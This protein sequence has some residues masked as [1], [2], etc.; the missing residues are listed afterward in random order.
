M[1]KI[2]DT[3]EKPEADTSEKTT[4]IILKKVLEKFKDPE[5]YSEIVKLKR[6]DLTTLLLHVFGDRASELRPTDL[7]AQFESDRFVQP[8]GVSQKEFNEFDHTSF[9]S[10][11]TDIEVIELS[12][13]APIGSNSVLTRISQNN[14]LTTSRSTE[15]MADTVT[16]LAMECAKRRKKSSS[17]IHLC[18]SHRE[19][20]AQ[21]FEDS[22]GFLPHFRG[23]SLVS[24]EKIGRD[25]KELSEVIKK[26]IRFYLKIISAAETAG[27]VD[28]KQ[29]IVKISS[30]RILNALINA[31]SLDRE[32]LMRNTGNREYSLFAENSITLP[33]ELNPGQVIDGELT[34][35]YR[36][37]YIINYLTRICDPI[38]ESLK[39]E[40]PSVQFQYDLSRF[41]GLGYYED[42]CFKI[43]AINV[44]GELIPLAD[45]G[46]TD[47]TEK[48]L[49]SKEERCF[50]GGF[51][52][53]FFIS[54]FK[55][56]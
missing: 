24:S 21:K 43:K 55:K 36:V 40:F 8:S 45:A 13:V 6:E 7:Q 42:L 10:L 23:I 29:V 26:H 18:T 22:T 34:E 31:L 19:V 50:A 52:S 53:E 47:W 41:E 51:G 5:I 56:S 27:L 44:N 11:D 33:E 20:R 17:P 30:L 54:K 32:I 4:D 28:C 15:V 1:E 39:S 49:Q 12:P 14:I 3:I 38:I 25:E 9:E 16:T 37:T 48:L 35:K 2:Q 46:F